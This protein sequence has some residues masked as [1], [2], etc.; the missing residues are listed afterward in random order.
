MIPSLAQGGGVPDHTVA[1]SRRA[2]S[3]YVWENVTID[4]SVARA[5]Q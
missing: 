3:E 2:A 4:S 5:S 1:V